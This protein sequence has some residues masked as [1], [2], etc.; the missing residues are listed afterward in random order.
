MVVAVT[1][2]ERADAITSSIG[3]TAERSS[4][5]TVFTG[6]S[7]RRCPRGRSGARASAAATSAPRGGDEPAPRAGQAGEVV[8][9][10]ETALPRAQPQH[11][12]ECLRLDGAADAEAVPRVE[13]GLVDLRGHG[14]V[15]V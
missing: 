6:C 15:G 5:L 10:L 1:D 9:V 12:L 7:A 4:E 13:E 2:A 8:V 3:A 11:R 14:V